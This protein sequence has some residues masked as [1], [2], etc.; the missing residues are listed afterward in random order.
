MEEF[1]EGFDLAGLLAPISPE[2]PAG[3]DLREDNAL[4]GLYFR[5][6]EARR[7]ASAAERAAEAPSDNAGPRPLDASPVSALQQW[8]TL[9]ELAIEALTGHSKDLEIAAWLTEALLRSD[10]LIGLTAGCRL[11]AGLAESFWDELFPQPDEEGIATRVAPVAAL[12]GVGRDG[13]LIQPLRKI[14]LFERPTDNTPLYFYQYEQSAEIA[15]ITDAE[16]RQER[17]DRGVLPLEIVE[18]E[19]QTQTA[20]AS[21]AEL[22]QRVGAT[23]EAWQSLGQTVDARAGADGP[24]TSR[25]RDLL[26]KIRIVADHFAAPE[27]A[28]PDEL[29]GSASEVEIAGAAGTVSA[30]V[31][32]GLASREDALRALAQIAEFFRRTEPL[33][34]ITYTLQ[35]AVRRSRLT[36]PEL[37]EEI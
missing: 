23:A 7:E 13:T 19:A 15:S 33:S 21:L 3:R 30:V 14:V 25:V 18:N 12:N 37:L 22:R 9:G 26:E 24:P 36:W 35:E 28:A 2:A 34:P 1:P 32:G 10:G 5:L 17:L 8:R 27:A 4:D 11:M 20:H 6:R 31:A 16:R 29:T